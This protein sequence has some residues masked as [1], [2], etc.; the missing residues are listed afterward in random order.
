[1]GAWRGNRWVN[2]VLDEFICARHYVPH[3]N[4]FRYRLW[5]A[6]RTRYADP[7]AE[8]VGLTKVNRRPARQ[9]ARRSGDFEDDELR[10]GA[11]GTLKQRS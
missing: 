2:H 9:A 1:M 10:C 11:A 3:M 5:K 8:P 7:G 4:D 6:H